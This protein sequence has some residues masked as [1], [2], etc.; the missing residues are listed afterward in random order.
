M[1]FAAV[2]TRATVAR[3]DTRVGE[4]VP[5]DEAG[6]SAGL[7]EAMNTSSHKRAVAGRKTGQ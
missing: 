5:V 1:I 2:V 3:E 6:L 4:A 7:Q